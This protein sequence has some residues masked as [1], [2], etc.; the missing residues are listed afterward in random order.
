[1]EITYYFLGALSVIALASVI[2]VVRIRREVTRT[3]DRRLRESETALFKKIDENN[4]HAMTRSELLEQ[5]LYKTKDDLLSYIDSKIDKQMNW[6]QNKFDNINK[7][8]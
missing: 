6:C 8:N 4:I 7:K 3:L 2:G 1:M 5:K